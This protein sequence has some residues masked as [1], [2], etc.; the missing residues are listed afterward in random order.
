MSKTFKYIQNDDVLRT[1]NEMKNTTL[2]E[3]PLV[4]AR[5]GDYSLLLEKRG[6]ETLGLKTVD[7]VK[8]QVVADRSYNVPNTTVELVSR[9]V[10]HACQKMSELNDEDVNNKR[11][12]IWKWYLLD[13]Q[14]KHP[15]E[16]E[17]LFSKEAIWD[18]DVMKAETDLMDMES[19]LHGDYLNLGNTLS[20]IDS[21][22]GDDKYREIFKNFAIADIMEMT[23]EDTRDK[24]IEEEEKKKCQEGEV[25]YHNYKFTVSV[26]ATDKEHA[27]AALLNYL[28]GDPRIKVQK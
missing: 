19:F 1:F 11:F 16:S 7:T 20:L 22:L 17:R 5:H 2:A 28:A 25:K 23:S 4:I 6:D 24:A 15:S 13:W 3:R 21:Y 18:E 27:R 8:N 26:E 14:K 9:G 10:R 12:Q